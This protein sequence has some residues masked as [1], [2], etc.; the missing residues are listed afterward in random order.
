MISFSSLVGQIYDASIS[1]SDWPAALQTIAEYTDS[2]RVTLI[3]ED[4]V[5]PVRSAYFLSVSDPSWD[6]KYIQKYMMLNPMRLST[7]GL[8][9]SGDIILTSDFMDHSEYRQSRFY[10]EFLSER[11][12]ID[13]AVA[14]L[15]KTATTITVLSIA[16]NFSQGIANEE[17]RQKLDLIAP[18]VRRAAAIGRILEQRKL[19]AATL[20]D[21][22]DQLLSSVFLVGSDGAVLHANEAAR[23]L[24]SEG[25]IVSQV[26]GR[27]LLRDP[28]SRAALSEALSWAQRGDAD[29]AARGLSLP[30]TTGDKAW[31]GTLMP[32]ARG[33]RREAGAVYR[34]A[35]ALCLTEVKYQRPSAVPELTRLYGLTPREMTILLAVVESG[36]IPEISALLGIS[37]TTVRG[38]VKSIFSKTGTNRQ[39]DLVKLV[40]SASTPFG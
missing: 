16:R 13:I 33:A 19:E 2:E 9:R 34:A 27:L 29:L 10:R 4:A 1:P 35:A 20:S 11:Q 36:G 6:Q 28:H 38:H 5:L 32:L 30:L 25:V 24:V 12:I 3:L 40:T 17:I 14:V 22:L 21:T 26:G 23:K 7:V 18:H 39:A 15:E 31:I 37:E 8:A